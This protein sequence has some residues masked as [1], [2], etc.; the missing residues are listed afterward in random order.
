MGLEHECG[1]GRAIG[2]FLEPLACLAL[3]GKK[4]LT[5]TLRCA[6][7]AA[8]YTALARARQQEA[9]QACSSRGQAQLLPAAATHPVGA[10]RLQAVC[11]PQLTPPFRSPPSHRSGI[12]NDNVDCGV[13]V[14]RTVTL[15]LLR[16]LT[17]AEDG[18]ELKVRHACCVALCRLCLLGVPHGAQRKV[19][20]C[21]GAWQPHTCHLQKPCR[22]RCL[23]R[24]AVQVVKRGAPPLGGG[25]VLVRLPVVRQLPPV[26]WALRHVRYGA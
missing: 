2:W 14:W 24:C 3:W 11:Q 1:T 13:D 21:P 4:P 12:T 6:C 19:C 26:R 16:Q 10:R 25:E 23:L 8:G 15:P 20:C 5:I 22:R 9:G 7:C 18:F 17:G